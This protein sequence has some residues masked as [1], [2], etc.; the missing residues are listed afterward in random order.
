MFRLSHTAV[1]VLK[2]LRRRRD[3]TVRGVRH[4]THVGRHFVPVR[5]AAKR[6]QSIQEI[7]EIKEIQEIKKFKK[8]KNQRNQ[9]IKESK[10]SKN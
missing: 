8:S 6:H 7:K 1:V 2:H 10:K 3:R 9:R 4:P 5:G